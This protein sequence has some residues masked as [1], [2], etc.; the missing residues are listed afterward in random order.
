M[1]PD[2]TSIPR[3]HS[4]E[5]GTGRLELKQEADITCQGEGA[6]KVA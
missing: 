2:I 1:P 6:L 5:M 3:P 4:F